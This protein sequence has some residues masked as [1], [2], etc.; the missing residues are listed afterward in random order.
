VFVVVLMQDST[1]ALRNALYVMGVGAIV[2]VLCMLSDVSPSPL[3]SAYTRHHGSRTI[4]TVPPASMRPR[5][6]SIPTSA[7][8][9]PP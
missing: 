4:Q 8:S 9:D 2:F 6:S 5:L 3:G 1:A 7:D